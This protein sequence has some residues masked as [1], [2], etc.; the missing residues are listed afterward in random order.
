MV[1]ILAVAVT[2]LAASV[3]LQFK[4]LGPS[5]QPRFQG[6]LELSGLPNSTT[7]V[8]ALRSDQRSRMEMVSFQSEASSFVRVLP[9]LELY[10]VEGHPLRADREIVLM[11]LENNGMALEF[12]APSL[13]ADFDVCMVACQ[14]NGQAIQFV[15]ARQGRVKR[16]KE[17]PE[18]GIGSGSEGESCRRDYNRVRSEDQEE[19]EWTA[20]RKQRLL[21]VAVREAGFQ[22]VIDVAPDEII[23]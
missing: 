20:E 14:Q 11:A 3:P 19:E 22:L 15:D 2:G 6:V 23:L 7:S 21:N 4:I 9:P 17:H 5:T 13:R 16:R 8:V 12:A 1:S 18:P 10:G